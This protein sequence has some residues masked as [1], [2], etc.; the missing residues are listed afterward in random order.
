M[1]GRAQK[2]QFEGS[3]G[4]PLVGWAELPPDGQPIRAWALFAHCF[5]CTKDLRSA[6]RI[7][8][9]LAKD[10]YAVLRFDFTGLGESEG[11]FT[12][13]DF[14][15][16]RDDLIAAANHLRAHEEAPRLLIGHSLGGTAALSAAPH[17]PEVVAVAVLRARRA[18]SWC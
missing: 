17:I 6:K 11:D 14:S 5:T 13:T 3:L 9:A 12:G 1:A 4:H 15:S 10:G 18:T 7:T 2:M 8:T 16:N